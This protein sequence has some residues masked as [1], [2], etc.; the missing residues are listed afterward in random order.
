MTG[1]GRDD[2]K[3]AIPVR[4]AEEAEDLPPE[5]GE[6]SGDVGTAMPLLRAWMDHMLN[7]FALTT[8]VPH[9]GTERDQR[10]SFLTGLA[11]RVGA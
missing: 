8:Q 7:S 6:A 10:P 11:G 5:A 3:F 9:S 4:A 2:G 1:V